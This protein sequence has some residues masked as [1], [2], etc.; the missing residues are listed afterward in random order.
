MY[1]I[2]LVTSNGYGGTTEVEYYHIDNYRI[3]DDYLILEKS[4]TGGA[5]YIP[6]KDVLEFE[7]N[8]KL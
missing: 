7:L 6:K 1:T 3:T 4:R 8:R 5:Y 2:T